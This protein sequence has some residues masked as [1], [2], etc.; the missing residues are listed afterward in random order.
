M[1]AEAPRETVEVAASPA[2]GGWQGTGRYL[3]P[4]EVLAIEVAEGAGWRVRIGCHADGLWGAESWA[5]WPEITLERAI[6][7]GETRLASPFGGP[8]YLIAG[9]GAG[10]LRAKLAGTVAAPRYVRDD[11]ASVAAWAERRGAPGPWAELEGRHLVLSV[12]SAA[13][14]DLADPAPVLEY[15]DSVVLSHCDLGGTPPPAVRERFVGDAQIAAGYMHSGYPIMTWLDVV[16]PPASGGPAPVLDLEVLRREGNWGYF[17]E[18]GHNRQ[19]PEWTFAGTGEVTCNLFTLYTMEKVAGI[20]A[21][22]HD[23]LS[24]A[25]AAREGFL[26]RGAPFAEWQADPFL[27]LLTYAEV[28]RELGWEP[29]RAVFREYEALAAEARPREEQEKIDQ[30]VRRLSRAAGRDLRPHHRAWGWPLGAA[31][32]A[33]PEL[34]ALPPF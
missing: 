28:Q 3:P 1:A 33:D 2:I 11:P 24:G 14:R 22:E 29:F 8:V 13:V 20:P 23:A 6:A 18:L 19:R 21:R 32:A 27:A 30:W 16:T 34:A 17:H 4:G 15:W 26:A 9:P 7:A 31:L 5:R 10:P 12:P 25:K